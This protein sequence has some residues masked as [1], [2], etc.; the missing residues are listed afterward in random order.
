[1][2]QHNFENYELQVT[3]FVLEL[4]QWDYMITALSYNSVMSVNRKAVVIYGSIRI[5][6][7]T[8]IKLINYV[9]FIGIYPTIYVRSGWRFGKG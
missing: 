7:F 1:M 8:G 3:N 5:Y 4:Y 6:G 2:C 9:C